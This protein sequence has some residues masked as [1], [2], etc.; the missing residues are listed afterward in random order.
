MIKKQLIIA[1]AVIFSGHVFS[2]T[3]YKVG[4]INSQELLD[5]MPESDSAQA[6]LENIYK[7][8]QNQSEMMQV[9]FNNKYQDYISKKSSYSKAIR[10]VKESELQDMNNRIQQF[11]TS[12][13]EDITKRKTEIFKPILDKA[14][15]AI[16]DVAKEN[17]FAYVFDLSDGSVIYHAENSFDI[18]P[19]VKQKLDIK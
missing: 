17:N 1:L 14:Q 15:K 3:T 4:H 13:Q 9:E 6:K 8:L 19:L 11:Q 2:Q 7:E 16:S 18:L 5:A 10:Q 12:A